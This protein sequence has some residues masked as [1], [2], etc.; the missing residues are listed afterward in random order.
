[1]NDNIREPFELIIGLGIDEYNIDEYSW[2]L[3][4]K[5]KKIIERWL[6]A[7]GTPQ[8]LMNQYISVWE[9][10]CMVIA[11]DKKNKW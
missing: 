11:T 6:S 4:K 10:W 8:R 9:L 2:N 7:N 1:L 3:K 5:N